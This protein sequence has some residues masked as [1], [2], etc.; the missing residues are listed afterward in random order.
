[1]R[2]PIVT[3][4]RQ[5]LEGLRHHVLRFLP[6]ES[7]DQ[8]DIDPTNQQQF[9][10]PV[11]LHRRDGRSD[12]IKG[13]Q[14]QDGA[15]PAA[16]D[17][18]LPSLVPATAE[19]KERQRRDEEKTFRQQTKDA[20]QS[21]IAPV[22][23][24]QKN[25]KKK[26][27]A[28]FEKAESK[29]KG[30]TLRY[31]ESLAWHIEDFEGT[32]LWEGAY[33]Q[34]AS[35]AQ[36]M[37]VKRTNAAGQDYFQMVPCDKWYKFSQK[38]LV[39]GMSAEDAE[40]FMSTKTKM[41]RFILEQIK[42]EAEQKKME[43]DSH[44]GIR[45]RFRAGDRYEEAAELAKRRRLQDDDYVKSEITGDRE[46]M[47][48]NA[49]EEF[50]DDDE[51][52]L[53]EGDKDDKEAAQ[54]KIR[55]DQLDANIWKHFEGRDADKEAR[56]EKLKKQMDRQGS[57]GVRKYLRKRERNQLYDE[58]LDEDSDE[59]KPDWMESASEESSDESGEEDE[60]MKDVEDEA[61]KAVES[62]T[63]KGKE[64]VKS[65]LTDRIKDKSQRKRPHAGDASETSGNESSAR[66]KQKIGQHAKPKS[67]LSGPI[68]RPGSPT[69]SAS[70]AGTNAGAKKMKKGPLAKVAGGASPPSS[71]QGS[72]TP[73]P[74][75]PRGQN[76]SPG[77]RTVP[78]LGPG[79]KIITD[80]KAVEKPFQN[81]FPTDEQLKSVLVPGSKITIGSFIKAFPGIDHRKEEFRAFTKDRLSHRSVT[82]DG[83]EGRKTMWL[84]NKGEPFPES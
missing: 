40:K 47:D 48:Y 71:R 19:D 73:T 79:A 7:S 16:G 37:L 14:P 31:E 23:K 69:G 75:T 41:P 27:D 36:V 83:S 58:S 21:E 32:N 28:V 76:G 2:Y 62:S 64:P 20:I 30:N 78:V 84:W 49:D 59:A 17:S 6:H 66:K 45:P 74:G 61:K 44:R 33:E 24:T 77:K 42:K 70:S 39:R 12:F 57:K 18:P 63:E 38:G 34:G 29:Q 15:S 60:A 8:Q 43:E 10:R 53:F 35:H 81:K 1:M 82:V 9:T 13:S 55:R 50:Q 52:D 4:K 22:I 67:G 26:L 3:T 54:E 5:L 25:K 80:S 68:V 11:R 56:E 46:D 51:N 72:P 65:K